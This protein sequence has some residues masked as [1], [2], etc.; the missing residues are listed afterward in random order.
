MPATNRIQAKA[1]TQFE[2]GLSELD[3][4]EEAL[5]YQA[6]SLAKKTIDGQ[7]EQDEAL[8]AEKFRARMAEIQSVLGKLHNQKAWYVPKT[9]VPLG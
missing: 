2:I 3:I 6:H 4:I 5:R 1:Q 7:E 9:A 8:K